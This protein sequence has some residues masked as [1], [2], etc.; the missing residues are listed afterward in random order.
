[1]RMCEIHTTFLRWIIST[2]ANLM[3]LQDPLS[4]LKF[5]AFDLSISDEDVLA[6]PQYHDQMVFFYQ[7][8]RV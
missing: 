2:G 8:E 5:S 4:R 3:K 7:L 1:M 6:V